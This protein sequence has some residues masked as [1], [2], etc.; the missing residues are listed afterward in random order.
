MFVL[1]G[2]VVPTIHW[3][4]GFYPDGEDLQCLQECDIVSSISHWVGDRRSK[5]L[6]KSVLEEEV[7]RGR[8]LLLFVDATPM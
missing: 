5:T 3:V 4:A 1:C 8:L 6:P 7:A 2:T